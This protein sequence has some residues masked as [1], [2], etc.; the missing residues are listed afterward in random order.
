M[1]AKPMMIAT[2]L[3]ILVAVACFMVIRADNSGQRP[4]YVT[5][6]GEIHWLAQNS[7]DDGKVIVRIGTEQDFGYRIGD[8]VHVRV[9]VVT[10]P[11]VQVD[12]S[13]IQGGTLYPKAAPSYS[14]YGSSPDPT[15]GTPD[16]MLFEP[17]KITSFLSDGK[18]IWQLDLTLQSF[19]EKAALK[20]QT[21]FKYLSDDGKTWTTQDSPAA[22]MYTTVS[23]QEK[24]QFD[25]GNLANQTNPT[26][27]VVRVLI[28]LSI[29]S[30]ACAL[31]ILA[32]GYR[33]KQKEIAAMPANQRAWQTIDRVAADA[34]RSGWKPAHYARVTGALMRYLGL[35]YTDVG[36][37]K[38]SP[39]QSRRRLGAVLEKVL[40][41]N[42]AFSGAETAQLLADLEK[43]VPRAE[44]KQ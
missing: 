20:F 23:A 9:L 3:V 11:S 16:F 24:D 5:R 38:S 29:W 44:V 15:A 8:L 6:S 10:D 41:A 32:F 17:A 40:Y 4:D 34:R 13:A 36:A 12:F 39:D 2:T 31:T 26:P 42:E 37:L 43:V 18:R 30:T 22:D 35:E 28:W 1:F 21:Q 25:E 19:K 33:K 7:A 27:P 14:Y